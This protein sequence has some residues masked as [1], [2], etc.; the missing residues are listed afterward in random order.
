VFQTGALT[1]AHGPEQRK[2]MRAT[3]LNKLTQLAVKNAK[4]NG[5]L[6]DG[7][8][9][10][11][12]RGAFVFRYTSAL[13]GK[14]TDLSLGSAQSVS[15]KAARERAAELRQMVGLGVDPRSQITA[16][17]QAAKAAAAE[18]RTFGEVAQLWADDV[19]PRHK[20]E[21]NRRKIRGAIQ[22]H[23]KALT[24]VAMI[25]VTSKMIANCVSPLS[26]RPAQR[27]SV[28]S[29]IH[30]IFDWAMNSD[31]IPERL[32]PARRAK[33]KKLGV[34]R[35]PVVA[36]V[37]H[38]SF[39][40]LEHLPSFME[41]LKIVPGN[42]ARAL[43]FLI[44][45]GLRQAE[46]IGLRW[47]YVDMNDRSIT[48][49]AGAMKAG[50]AHRVFLSDHAFTIITALQPQHRP[51][52]FVFPGNTASGTLGAAS[53]GQLIEQR[54]PDV[55]VVQVHGCRASLKTWAT[56]NTVHRREIIELTLA[57]AVGGAVES[58]YLRDN[59]TAIRKARQS[60]YNDWSTF[61][62]GGSKVVQL[63]DYAAA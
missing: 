22:L 8:G 33:L 1:G 17:H 42:L 39:V 52:G 40:P 46:V 21:A 18:A 3:K 6:S 57:H 38:N 9:L 59:D 63:K 31:L 32:N 58:A 56:A 26:D 37:K 60:L 24:K 12:R 50:K 55:G 2:M 43:E 5:V 48:I 15:L 7:G 41:R 30:S 45:T 28:V 36:P 49:P 11:L 29:I 16:Q 10:Y 14:E 51:G 53:M 20:S 23:T 13:T 19:L 25:E 47:N 34:H 62:R 61:L 4:P 35:D 27:D 44:H 54:F